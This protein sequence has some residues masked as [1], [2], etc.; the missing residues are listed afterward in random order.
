MTQT[1]AV[2]STLLLS[3]NVNKSATPT[4]G[5]TNH[6]VY[7]HLS[8]NKKRQIQSDKVLF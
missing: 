2:T 6:N 1:P 8:N 4:S 5:G 7:A 3:N